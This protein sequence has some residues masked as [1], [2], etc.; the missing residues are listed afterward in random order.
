MKITMNDIRRAGGPRTD[1]H[2]PF[3]AEGTD[4]LNAF[5]VAVGKAIDET[6][7]SM[8]AAAS[9]MLAALE[10]ML[11]DMRECGILDFYSEARGVGMAGAV[12]EARAAIAKAKGGSA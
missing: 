10:A 9:D 1:F 8:F 12:A 2:A 7:G 5:G 6:H 4:V 11:A 3:K